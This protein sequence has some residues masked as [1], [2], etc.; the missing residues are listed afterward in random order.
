[1]RRILILVEGQA[2]AT[3]VRE[4]LAPHL[5][6]LG[7]YPVA[8]LATTKRVKSGSDFKGG[9]RTY[10]KVKN[11]LLRLLPD[12]NAALVTTMLD[13]YGLPQ[14]FPG[15][16]KMPGGSCYERVVHLESEFQKDIRHRKFL[17]YLELHE[18][19]AM[20]F[21]SPGEIAKLFPKQDVKEELL[22]IK[23]E[24]QS[25]EEINDNPNTAPSKRLVSLLPQYQKPLHGPLV[26]LEI[27]LERIRGECP[28][29][30]EWLEKLEALGEK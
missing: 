5:S 19:E 21:V 11:D 12:S 4:V 15:R 9:V 8:K 13:F 24:F 28:H 17:P 23:S 7:V 25:P 18:F 1:M 2:E 22:T 14:D 27:G 3:F 16:K 29:F 6:N 10:G 30:N 20:M 26:I